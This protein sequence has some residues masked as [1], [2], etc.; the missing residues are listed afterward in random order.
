MR[1]FEFNKFKE[2]QKYRNIDN[3]F[4]EWLVG[5]FEGD[6]SLIISSKNTISFVITQASVNKQILDH[7]QNTLGFGSVI[8]QG[9][10]T[11]RFI[12]QNLKDIY[13]ILILLNGNLVLVSRKK[14]FLRILENFN[15]R[16]Q[17]KPIK[18]LDTDIKPSLQDAWI[19]GFTDAEGCFTVSF[20]RATHIYRI[21]FILS[22]KG[23]ENLPI[24]S[25]FILNFKT[26]TI[27]SHS[28]G[29]Q[30]YSFIINGVENCKTILPYFDKFPLKTSKLNSFKIWSDVLN[31]IQQKQ[32]LNSKNL[33][34]L[35]D[36][37]KQINKIQ[38][39][40]YF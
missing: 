39:S 10:R 38:K 31:K 2:L 28:V 15:N 4:L 37:A 36:K 13:K 5:F 27:E 9:P 11:Y 8:K 29:R 32:H 40:T 24:L 3:K 21:R 26:G 33:I 16:K 35:I 14:Q 34:D 12:V 1:K 20:L 19:S 23:I 25:N 22:Q 17:I 18:Y 7:I 6:G 30:N